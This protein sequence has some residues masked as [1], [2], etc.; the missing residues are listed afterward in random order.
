MNVIDELLSRYATNGAI[1]KK[2]KIYAIDQTKIQGQLIIEDKNYDA[3]VSDCL[4]DSRSFLPMLNAEIYVSEKLVGKH[5]FICINK[6][7]IAYLIEES[8][9]EPLLIRCP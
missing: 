9:Q 5:N 1:T 2:I 8:C 3:R 6:Q 7:I 4:N